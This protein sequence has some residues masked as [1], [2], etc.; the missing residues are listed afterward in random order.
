MLLAFMKMLHMKRRNRYDMILYYTYNY[1]MNK[2][3]AK[4]R[5]EREREK[6]FVGWTIFSNLNLL[7]PTNYHI[8]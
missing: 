7:L 3:T 5:K 4:E 6:E 1:Y 8:E 2:T